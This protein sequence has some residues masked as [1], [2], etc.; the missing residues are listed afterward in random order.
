[1]KIIYYT[2][3]AFIVLFG[4]INLVDTVITNLYS[5]KK[6]FGILQAVGMSN[7]QLKKMINKEMLHYTNISVV[8]IDWFLAVF[9]D[10]RL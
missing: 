3:A 2:L 1:M 8:C 7:G 5:R 9:L 4:I 6:E 10:M